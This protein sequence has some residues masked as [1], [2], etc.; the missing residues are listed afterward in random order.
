MLTDSQ[1]GELDVAWQTLVRQTACDADALAALYQQLLQHYRDGRV[2][3]GLGHVYALLGHIEQFQQQGL[4][5]QQQAAICAWA[6]W[7]HDVIY[8]TKAKDN[9]TKSAV[10]AADA[11]SQLGLT[12]LI[13]PVSALVRATAGHTLQGLPRQYWYMAAYFLDADIAILGAD[14]DTYTQYADAIRQEYAWV[15]GFLYRR[16]RRKLLLDFLA[17]DTIYFSPEF[18][19]EREAKARENLQAELQRLS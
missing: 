5:D 17:R 11:L 19:A 10:F 9:E 7:F 16:G 13:S 4:L 6:V 2:Y 14:S 15:P 12:Q 8:D 18:K 3:H 1:A